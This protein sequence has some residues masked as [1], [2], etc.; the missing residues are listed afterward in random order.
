MRDENGGP[1]Y[2]RNVLFLGTYNPLGQN[3]GRAER[4][5]GLGVRR[6]RD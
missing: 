2:K 5:K 6:P 4:R 3:F 1:G